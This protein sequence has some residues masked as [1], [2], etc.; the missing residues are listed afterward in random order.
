MIAPAM[1][2]TVRSPGSALRQQLAAVEEQL[3]QV[4]NRSNQDPLNYPIRLNNRIA[5]LLGVV[6]GADGAPTRQSYQVFDR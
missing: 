2:S 3:Y 1:D 4:R 6:E 5:A